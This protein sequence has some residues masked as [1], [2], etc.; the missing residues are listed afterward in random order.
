MQLQIKT[1]DYD[2]LSKLF[3]ESPAEF[4]ALRRKILN[5]AVA[6]TDADHRPALQKTLL[7]IEE[8]R[9]TAAT[10]LEAA[11]AAFR[12]MSDSCN[13]LK[14]EWS[15]L[16]RELTTLQAILLLERVRQVR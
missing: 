12:L 8:A 13:L 11:E 14:D 5:E 10:P 9:Q 4:E 6:A 16:N 3:Q 1:P 7:C 2:A 15:V